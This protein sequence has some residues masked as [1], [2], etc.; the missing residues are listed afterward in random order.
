[1]P[2]NTASPAP[3]TVEAFSFRNKVK[4]GSIPAQVPVAQRPV[5]IP[6]VSQPKPKT[7]EKLSAHAKPQVEVTGLRTDGPTLEEYVE[8]G[9]DADNYPPEGYA[10]RKKLFRFAKLSGTTAKTVFLDGSFYQ[11]RPTRRQGGGYSPTT[12]CETTDADLAAKLRE[13]AKTDR[14]I[15]EAPSL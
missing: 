2:E 13:A 8:A 14:S 5:V 1:M 3:K 10:V 4:A 7:V 11:W 9:Y 15:R 12:S 6:S